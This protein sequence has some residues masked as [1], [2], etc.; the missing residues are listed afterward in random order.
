[1]KKLII[2]VLFIVSVA[3]AQLVNHERICNVVH[4]LQDKTEVFYCINT[5]DAIAYERVVFQ[6]FDVFPP[7]IKT[8]MKNGNVI[9]KQYQTLPGDMY[10]EDL[11]KDDNGTWVSVSE[12]RLKVYEMY[13]PL[14]HRK[15]F[16]KQQREK[17]FF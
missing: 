12:I 5:S 11:V 4:N 9:V 6:C 16:C 1:M 3:T 14:V 7:S 15:N 10:H 8:V 2:A 17:P 13:V